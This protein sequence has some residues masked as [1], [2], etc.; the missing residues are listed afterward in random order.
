[1]APP[2]APPQPTPGTHQQPAGTVY[3]G[4]QP[5]TTTPSAGPFPPQPGTP[6]TAQPGAH[7][8][9]PGAQQPGHPGAQPGWAATGSPPPSTAYG[10]PPQGYATPG[11]RPPGAPPAPGPAAP[12]GPKKPW[13]KRGPILAAVVVAVVL[14]VGCVG[15]VLLGAQAIVGSDY[16]SGKCIKR[17]ASGDKDRA[18]PVECG[19]D[20][21][22]KII[23]RANG[24]TTVQDG[25]CPP[26]TTDAFVNFKDEYVLCLRKED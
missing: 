23:D 8:G 12:A 18:I 19:T 22:Y 17:E 25:S 5:G 13:Y 1:M 6:P 26:D 4:P 15:G 2:T 16:S 11:T 20:G 9:Q 24:T 7:P 10:P 14:L 21:S 3:G